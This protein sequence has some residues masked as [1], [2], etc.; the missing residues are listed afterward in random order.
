[1]ANELIINYPTG[2]TLYAL[3]FDATG[4]IYN[5]STFVAPGS[6]NW[7]SYD[8]ALTEVATA[9]GIYRGNMPTVTTGVYSFVVRK[10]AGGS[11]AVSDVVVG[12]GELEWDGSA[13]VAPSATVSYAT[14]AELKTYLGISTTTDDTLLDDILVRTKAAIDAYTGRVFLASADTTHYLDA[15]ADVDGRTLLLRG[16][17]CAITTVTNG[18]T[19]VISSSYYVT[20]PRNSVTPYYAITLK[21][22]AP[23]AWTYSTEPENAISVLGRWAYSTT[24]PGD[25]VQACLAWAKQEYRGKDS[26]TIEA[27]YAE[28]GLVTVQPGIPKEVRTKLAKYV[29]PV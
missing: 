14:L 18:D 24:P 7:T 3:L 20:E 19:T 27:A 21:S 23:Y 26:Q 17:C 15:C 25:I 4:Q 6:T 8:I 22:S 10:Q 5:G 29:R 28:Q 13:V 12:V 2:A 1:M 16:D 11:P 9:T